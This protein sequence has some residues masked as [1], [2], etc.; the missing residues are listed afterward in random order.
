[1]KLESKRL[2]LREMTFDDLDFVAEM[3]AHPEVM[4]FY[5]KRFN[6]SEARDWLQGQLWRYENHGYGLWLTLEKASSVTVGQVGLLRKKVLGQ[7]EDE[8]GYLLHRPYWGRGYATEAAAAVRDY[9]FG[10]LERERVVSLIRPENLPSRRVAERLGMKP[11]DHETCWGWEHLVYGLT[12]R[13][14]YHIGC[15][16]PRA[17]NK[18]ARP[19][20]EK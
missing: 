10:R 8:I 17:S 6:R 1:M 15:D 3:L 11:L 13:R 20:G 18:P 14:G 9:A 7:D 4:R 5:P 19:R 2:L 16:S 12:R